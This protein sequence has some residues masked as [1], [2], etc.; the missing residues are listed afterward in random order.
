[1]HKI[2]VELDENQAIAL[3]E[4]INNVKLFELDLYE[5]TIKDTY[6]LR[7]AINKNPDIRQAVATRVIK[8]KTWTTSLRNAHIATGHQWLLAVGKSR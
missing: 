6:S 2:K 7:M 8:G 5:V 1:M 3:F 4:L